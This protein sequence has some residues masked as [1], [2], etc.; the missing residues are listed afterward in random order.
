M[1]AYKSTGGG[2]ERGGEGGGEERKGRREVGEKC[3]HTLVASYPSE[4]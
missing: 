2:G 4:I 3:Q 1:S